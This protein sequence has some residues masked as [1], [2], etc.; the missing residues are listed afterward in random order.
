[1]PF[2]ALVHSSPVLDVYRVRGAAGGG[3]F[4]D[5]ATMAGF[6][7]RRTRVPAG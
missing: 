7:C 1:V 6:S 4:P 5:P 2:L 3:S